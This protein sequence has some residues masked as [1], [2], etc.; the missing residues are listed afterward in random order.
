MNPGTQVLQSR[1]LGSGIDLPSSDAVL[2]PMIG[3]SCIDIDVQG[4]G[5]NRSRC[6]S[7][8]D[9]EPQSGASTFGR[10]ARF[11]SGT[12]CRRTA[13]ARVA[14]EIEERFGTVTATLSPDTIR[15]GATAREARAF[16]SESKSNR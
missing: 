6:L 4:D 7:G 16:N 12:I 3:V 9:D 13:T 11:C 10:A 8:L 1:D 14:T 15:I 5:I 2:L